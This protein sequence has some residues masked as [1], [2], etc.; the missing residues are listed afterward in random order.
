MRFRA[1]LA[2]EEPASWGPFGLNCVG[3][4]IGDRSAWTGKLP[5][6]AVTSD[7]LAFPGLIERVLVCLLDSNFEFKWDPSE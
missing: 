6:P 1:V 4:E 5:R 2:E 7:L 3:L